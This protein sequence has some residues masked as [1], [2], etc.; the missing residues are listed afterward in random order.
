[1]EHE[2]ILWINESN[3]TI[4]NL[5]TKPNPPSKRNMN[6]HHYNLLREK[7]LNIRPN[8]VRF[9]QTCISMYNLSLLIDKKFLLQ[10]QSQTATRSYEVPST[11]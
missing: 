3:L 2:P 10:N 6:S 1:M 4:P 8:L 7:F 9:R 11:H 5:C